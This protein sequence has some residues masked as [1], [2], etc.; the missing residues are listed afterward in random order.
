[1]HFWLAI[2]DT[3]SV[4]ITGMNDLDQKVGQLALDVAEV[5]I[6]V[7]NIKDTLESSAMS[8]IPVLC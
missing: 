2:S 3:S 8:M 5:G 4:S 6:G 1:M 7:T